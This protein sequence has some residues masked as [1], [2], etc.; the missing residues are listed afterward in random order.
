VTLKWNEHLTEA[1]VNAVS[2]PLPIESLR[3]ART[4]GLMSI[5]HSEGYGVKR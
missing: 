2:G 5:S 1:L 3:A 4:S